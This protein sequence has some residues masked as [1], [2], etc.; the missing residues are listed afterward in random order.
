MKYY[1]I[2]IKFS[3]DNSVIKYLAMGWIAVV[4]N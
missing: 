4:E 2:I 1:P 3:H